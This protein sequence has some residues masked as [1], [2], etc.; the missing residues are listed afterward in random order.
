MKTANDYASTWGISTKEVSRY[1]AEG[2]VPG[3]YQE[4]I[5]GRATWL[6]PEGLPKPAQAQKGPR[7]PRKK[8]SE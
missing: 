6:I 2:R 4:I 5:K 7:G 8:P 1:C 3:A